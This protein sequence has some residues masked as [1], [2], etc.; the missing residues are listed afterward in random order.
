MLLNL[1]TNLPPNFEG[2]STNRSTVLLEAPSLPLIHLNANCLDTSNCPPY[3]VDSE[4]N[5][6][7]EIVQ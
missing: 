1:E 4:T 5:I 7:G 2:A 6:F 3:K